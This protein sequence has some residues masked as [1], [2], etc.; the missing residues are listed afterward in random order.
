VAQHYFGR[1]LA[2]PTNTHIKNQQFWLK[3]STFRAL[4]PLKLR[5]V[6]LKRRGKGGIG[7]QFNR[8]LGANEREICWW[9]ENSLYGRGNWP[10]NWRANLLLSFGIC[11]NQPKNDTLMGQKCSQKWMVAIYLGQFS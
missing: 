9:R 8:I 11:I 7:G 10:T 1:G 4:G 5:A 3:Y 6:I 2:P